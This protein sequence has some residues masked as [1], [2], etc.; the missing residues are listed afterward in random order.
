MAPDGQPATGG[1]V[2]RTSLA[3]R[4]T[5]LALA[6]NAGLLLRSAALEPSALAAGSAT[7]VL[8]VAA[9]CWLAGRNRSLLGRRAGDRQVERSVTIGLAT[10]GLSAVAL[11]N[12]VVIGRHG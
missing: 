6:V 1:H 4:R 11:A 2:E 12:L 9:L 10:V 5:V 7:L 3:W 8:L